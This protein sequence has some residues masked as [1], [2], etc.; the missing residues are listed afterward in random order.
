LLPGDVKDEVRDKW[1][2]FRTEFK[3]QIVNDI[4]FHILAKKNPMAMGMIKPANKEWA[5]NKMDQLLDSNIKF[6]YD[7]DWFTEENNKKFW[8]YNGKLDNIRGESMKDKLPELYNA[9]LKYKV[10]Y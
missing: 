7:E 9:M 5:I 2:T 8:Q 1:E 6:M 4:D 3:N 10:D